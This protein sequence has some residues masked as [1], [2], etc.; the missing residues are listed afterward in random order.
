MIFKIFLTTFM[1]SDIILFLLFQL[2]HLTDD[3]EQVF[4]LS[5]QRKIYGKFGAASGISYAKLW[6]SREEM[7]LSKEWE[8]V[9]YPHSVHQMIDLAREKNQEEELRLKERWGKCKCIKFTYFNSERISKIPCYFLFLYQLSPLLLN[10]E[11]W[12]QYFFIACEHRYGK[13]THFISVL[14]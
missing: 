3:E 7:S 10:F 11:V 5:L 1:Y 14:S 8:S 2:R 13:K 9:A 4:P 12:K 6:P